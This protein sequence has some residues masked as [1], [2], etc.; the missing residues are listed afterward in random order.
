MLS[1]VDRQS[2]EIS[3]NAMDLSKEADGM[4]DIHN[5]ILYHMDDGSSSI[6]E[7]K[8]ML[9]IAVK[10]GITSIIA[11]PHYIIGSNGYVLHELNARYREVC[12]LI[13]QEQLP[14]KLYLGNEL[15]A[16][17]MLTDKLVEGDCH[18]LNKSQYVLIEFSPGT[19][20]HI[21]E[22]IIYNVVLKGYRPIIA[23][24]ERTFNRKNHM[25]LLR[26]LIRKG[27]YIQVNGGSIKGLYGDEI[28]K[29]AHALLKY[30]MVH[31][32]ASDAHT[33]RRRAPKLKR[34]YDMVKNGYGEAYANRL[35]IENGQ[36]VIQ[37]ETVTYVEPLVQEKNG[38]VNR[39][40]C[41]FGYE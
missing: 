1:C 39:L 26:D 34:A 23:H 16:D 20:E 8:K 13:E 17:A 21:V 27:C 12:E 6:E 5:H 11:T 36:Q 22:T 41:I 2:I 32:V 35:F 7:T 38:F 31:F 40:R 29:F 24:P 33:S 10:E 3:D 19:S 18:T 25:E 9:H 30:K 14:I 4:I 15:F 28:R 37:H